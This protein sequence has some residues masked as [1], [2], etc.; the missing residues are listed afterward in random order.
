MRIQ[1]IENLT[2]QDKDDTENASCDEEDVICVLK[3]LEKTILNDITLTGIKNIK[4]VSMY[5]EHNNYEFNKTTNEYVNKTKWIINTDGTNLE[6]LLIHP[7]IDS[8]KTISNYIYEVYDTLGLQAAR[9]VLA[10]EIFDVFDFAGSYVNSRHINLLVDIIT[11]R[12]FLMS[13]YRHCINKSDRGPLAKCS[14]EETPDI[15]ARAAIFG[16]L[17]KIQSVSANIMLGQEVPIVTGASELLF[18]EEKYF[19]NIITKEE[20]HVTHAEKDDGDKFTSAY[21]DN[22]F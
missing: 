13:I 4:G 12:G 1:L 21:C 18:D 20:E 8:Y 2:S 10:K 19:Q 5:Q 3:S 6:D 9:Q 17:Y 14:F 22:L 11:N 16:E 7:A 15:I